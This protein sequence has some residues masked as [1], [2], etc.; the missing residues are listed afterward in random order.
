MSDAPADTQH[1][2]LDRRRRPARRRRGR[3]RRSRRRG[4]GAPSGW[5]ARSSA[6]TLGAPDTF[7]PEAVDQLLAH[8]R[9]YPLL[10]PA[11]EI[12]L[13]KRIERGDL[14]AK[15]LLVN[16]NLRLVASN[17]RRYQNQG[18]PLG[19]LVQEGMLGLIRAERE[20][21]LAQGLPLLH[22]R[23]P[24]DPSGDP[25]RPGEL[26][27]HDPPARPRRPALAQGRARR[28][29]AVGAP[30]PRAHAR[31]AR[32]RRPACRSS[33]SKRCA[34][35]APR[36]S[37]ST[38]RS[39]RTATR[40]SATCCPP[41]RRRPRRPPGTT[42]ASGSCTEA[43]SQLPETERKVLT[44][45]F[46]T[47]PRGAADA[48]RD[49]QA[50]R[51]LRR[52]GLPARAA[53]AEEARRVARAGGP[54]RGRVA[55]SSIP[56]ACHAPRVPADRPR[57]LSATTGPQQA[58]RR[59]ALSM[60]A[61][62]RRRTS[63]VGA[64]RR[65]TIAVGER[66]LA[67]IERFIGRRSLV[68]DATFFPLERF[69]WVEHI[70]DNWTVIREE[71]ERAARGPRRARRTSRTSPRTRSRSPTTTAGRRSSSTATASRPSSACEMCP[72]TAAL[73]REIPGMTTAMFSILSPRKHILDHRGPYK[74]VLRYHLGLIVPRGRRGL[75]D[76]RRRGH[77]P[78]GGGQEPDL[79]RH[80]QPR[81]LERHRRDARGAVRRRP[82][83]AARSRSR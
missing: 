73:M 28:A 68:G 75:P 40:R 44:L 1:H 22:L 77:P 51:L 10:T 60:Q 3:R 16:S 69:P 32:R 79:R 33:R 27:P 13:A 7:I 5:T 67:P 26:R 11:Q 82:A 29:R 78:L 9:R 65:V 56:A 12:D 17:A 25:A 55:T 18:L 53:R 23:D 63:P 64:G 34:T 72:R 54:A 61:V 31:G 35:S 74:G 36:S 46:G 49:R 15:E 57:Q 37:A 21:R 4:A 52:A 43:I 70:E 6:S 71:V 39:A 8:S 66:I 83:P 58:R 45:R 30:R 20:V 24:V 48:D 38:S 2:T 14:H 59:Q 50:A 47:G 81:G 80:L 62:R 76:P 41:T 42:S 19:D